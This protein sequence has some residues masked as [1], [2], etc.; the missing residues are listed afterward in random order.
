[1]NI[2]DTAMDFLEL[3]VLSIVKKQIG[4]CLVYRVG[5]NKNSF[6]CWCEIR[7]A[8]CLAMFLIRVNN[9]ILNILAVNKISDSAS[10]IYPTDSRR[11]CSQQWRI[12][13]PL[14]FHFHTAVTSNYHQLDFPH[15]TQHKF[16]L[17]CFGIMFYL[18]TR[19]TYTHSFQYTILRPSSFYCH[20][21]T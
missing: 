8:I 11:K 3:D 4:Q 20:R 14:H 12:I 19:T 7:I 6:N 9:Q 1:M 13:L 5:D 21:C 18:W 17:L 2:V 15:H 10:V 16:S